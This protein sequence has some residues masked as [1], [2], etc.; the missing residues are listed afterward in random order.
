MRDAIASR[1]Y[2]KLARDSDLAPDTRFLDGGG[3]AT[4]AKLVGALSDAKPC[5]VVTTSH[6]QPYPLDNLDLLFDRVTTG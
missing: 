2:A 1:I 3:A 5:L 6:G 4:S